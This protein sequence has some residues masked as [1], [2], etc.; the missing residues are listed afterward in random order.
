MRFRGWPGEPD[1]VLHCADCGE[2]EARYIDEYG[3]FVC[4]VCPIRLGSDAIKISDVPELI[5][6][7]RKMMRPV[8]DPA[9]FKIH[10][11]SLSTNPGRMLSDYINALKDLLGKKPKLP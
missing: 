7:V 10:G 1:I 3:H 5:K 9:H 8:D 4:G 6:L 11:E 2:N